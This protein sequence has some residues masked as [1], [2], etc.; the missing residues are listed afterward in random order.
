MHVESLTV[1]FIHDEILINAKTPTAI[2]YTLFGYAVG[3][4]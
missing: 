2:Y 1:H 4:I 3:R